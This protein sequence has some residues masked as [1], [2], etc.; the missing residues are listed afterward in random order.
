[1]IVVGGIRC[2]KFDENI[3]IIQYQAMHNPSLL[4]RLLSYLKNPI[5][6]GSP[7]HSYITSHKF[8]TLFRVTAL[9]VFLS[10]FCGVLISIIATKTSALDNHAVGEVLEKANPLLTFALAGI[11]A[12]IMEETAFR[13]WHTP[14]RIPL[15]IGIGSFVYFYTISFFPQI[16]DVLGNWAFPDKSSVLNNISSIIF[17]VLLWVATALI[18]YLLLKKEML[19]SKLLS[20]MRSHFRVWFY[21]AAFLFAALHITNYDISTTTL[22]LMPILILPQFLGGILM[23]W[24]RTNIGF[25]WGV[26]THALY[27]ISLLGPGLAIKFLSEDSQKKVFNN[28]NLDPLSLAQNDQLVLVFISL[29]LVMLFVLTLG[30]NLH[31]ILSYFSSRRLKN[32]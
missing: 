26:L 9:A 23:S 30:S 8:L 11:L 14:K 24:V 21:L 17:G 3:P 19:Y 6:P 10:F 2:G 12:P 29:Y 28:E 22:L 7:S 31:L 1:M 15:S 20:I 32:I 5:L 18:T 27:N 25:W 16:L 4:S 13:L